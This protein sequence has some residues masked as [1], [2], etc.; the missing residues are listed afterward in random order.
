M[1]KKKHLKIFFS[2]TKKASPTWVALLAAHLTDDQ[3]VA[4]STPARSA[5]FFCGDLITKYFPV[6]LSLPLIQKG[7]L[8]V[9]G[10]R[11]CTI[12]VNHLED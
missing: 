2:R 3:E 1:V 7:Q 9:S 12:Q 11:I 4:G 5:V 8:S 6:I 10:K